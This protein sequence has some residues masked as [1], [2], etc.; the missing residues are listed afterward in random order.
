[1]SDTVLILAGGMTPTIEV[2]RALPP[3]AMCIAADSGIDHAR[4]LG[5]V[6][7]VA[8]GD[9]DSV[10][11]DGLAWLRSTDAEIFE[12]PSRK[13][14]TDLELALSH[15]VDAEPDRIVVAAIGG[16]RLDHLLANFAVLA[17]SRYRGP[18]IDGLVGT[19]LVAVVHDSRSFVGEN[20]EVITLLA[21]H[22]DAEGV[23]TSGLAYPLRGERL[24]A[25]G[26]RGVSNYFVAPEA[27]VSLDSGTLLAVQPDR[28][29]LGTS[30]D[31][32]VG[33][34]E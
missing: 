24:T 11:D 26:S 30:A 25:G 21:M 13:A 6:P 33:N 28:L 14:E 4:N 9:F 22:G 15:A 27:T 31:G 29:E 10:S 3:A 5:I 8:V 32:G 1:M 17:S 20:G 7:D 23:V 16:G 18:Q 19:A 12:H 2:Q 34:E